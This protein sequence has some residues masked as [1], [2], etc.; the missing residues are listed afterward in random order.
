M[1]SLGFGVFWNNLLMDR[2]KAVFLLI[3][4]VCH[5][6]ALVVRGSAGG[7]GLLV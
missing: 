1:F 2:K 7:S 4:H 5:F 6:I 3:R